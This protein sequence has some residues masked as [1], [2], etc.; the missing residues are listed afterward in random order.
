MELKILNSFY[1]ILTNN[2]RGYG[3]HNM[4]MYFICKKYINLSHL[5]ELFNVTHEQS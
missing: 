1:E 3:L 2:S 5:G 4:L